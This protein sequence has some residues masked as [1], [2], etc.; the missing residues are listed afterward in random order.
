MQQKYSKFLFPAIMLLVAKTSFGQTYQWKDTTSGGYDYKIVTNDPM[1]TRFY[2]LPN[3]L[4]VILSRNTNEPRIAVNIPVRTGSNN[5]PSDHTGLAHYLEHLLFKGTDKFGTLDWKK[6]K[7]Y[8]DTITQ[9]Y[10]AYNA[11]QTTDTAARKQQY[12][13]IDSISG[14][15]SH[16]SI[17]NE[18]DKMM[19]ALGGQGSNAYT[20]VEQTVYTENIPSNALDKF[21]DL[22]GE[23]FR[24]PQ[25][26]IFH[27]ELEAVYEEKNRG[28]D[29]D[30]EKEWE[31]MNQFVFPKSNYGQQTT[32]GTIEDLKNPSLI[33]IRNYFN[34]YYVPN[35]MA[36]VM[37]GDFDPDAVIKDVNKYFGAMQSKPVSDYATPVE[38]TIVGPIVKTVVGPNPENVMIGYRIGHS[39]TKEA[40]MAELIG[41]LLNNGKAGLIDL[42]LNKQQKVLNASAFVN[43]M[44]DYGEFIL[45]GAP[46]QNQSLDE[47]RQLLLDQINQLK[48][49]N[50]D[51]SLLPAT[52]ANYKLDLLKG[53]EKNS[54]RVSMLTDIFVNSKGNEW[55]DVV[56]KLEQMSQVTKQDIID[57]AN[58][59]FTNTNYVVINKIKGIDSSVVK[60]DKPEIHAVETNADKQ[61]VFLKNLVS[62]PLPEMKPVWVDY[63]SEIQN[64]KVGNADV[65][66]VP[67]KEND[68]FQLSYYYDLG[69]YNNKYL[70]LALDYLDYLNTDKYTSDQISSQF[71]DLA[72][73]YSANAGG[74]NTSLSINGLNENFEKSVSLFEN[75]LRNCKPNAE[76]LQQLKDRYFKARQDA[77]SNKRAITSALNNYTVY[78]AKNPSNYTLTDDELK[79]VTSEQLISILHSLPDYQHK[80]LYYGPLALSKMEQSVSSLHSVPSKWLT[81]PKAVEF[82][83]I[84]YKE[85]EVFFANYDMV[86]AEIFWHQRLEDFAPSKVAITN[87]FNEYFGGN[88]GSVVFQT[89]RES[90][91]LAYSTYAYVTKPSEKKDPFNFLGYVGTQADK[92]VDAIATMNDLINNL[93]MVPANYNNALE[94]LKKNI[95]TQRI[96][97]MS[98][99]Y[100]YLS[101][102]KLGINDDYRKDLFADY[103]K[104]TLNDV[105]AYHDTELKGKPFAY[106]IIASDKKVDPNGLSKYGKVHVLTLKQ[107]F[108]Y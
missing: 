54:T 62:T 41:V 11:I 71:Y 30:N 39:D 59:L 99:I 31:L 17:A 20:S 85:N 46:L 69:E 100:N 107:L 93:P 36:I 108:G 24:N 94:T 50:F 68:L 47:V 22:Q 32:I 105:K 10:A 95:E 102:Q 81:A 18:Y 72:A 2:T 44:K 21:L 28:L 60:V 45:E 3:G 53:L 51:A 52:V 65:L 37:A 58:K 34:K 40:L 106:S 8:L 82:T 78:G 97:K 55:P 98:L 4:K 63:K 96:R 29:N 80:V 61:S 91:A 5:D 14:V 92:R 79:N 15:A 56:S 7:P 33:A 83:P 70:S 43:Q 48:K 84:K 35:N 25:F 12:H 75:L 101:N 42:N 23:R 57:Y 66:Y 26:R 73:D 49:G 67:N 1:K 87:A 6:E 86:Q 90:K 103:G 27:T 88:M 19:A 9:L 13:I 77:K 16:Y 38:P 76:A 74:K 104:M 89:I 64:G